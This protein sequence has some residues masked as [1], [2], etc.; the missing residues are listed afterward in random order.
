M[1][2]AMWWTLRVVLWMLRAMW[3]TL[4]AVLW[5]LRAAVPGARP[6]PARGGGE[7][8]R[9]EGGGGEGAGARAVRSVVIG[10]GAL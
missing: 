4:T 7:A 9:A 10:D 8:A 1:L 2:R 6:D 5:M 3:W